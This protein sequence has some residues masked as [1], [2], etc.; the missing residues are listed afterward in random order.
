MYFE[1]FNTMCGAAFEPA[2]SGATWQ[3]VVDRH[4]ILRTAFLWEGLE[5][6]VQAVFRRV[7]VPFDAWTG[8]TWSRH[9]QPAKLAR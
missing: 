4:P 9:E 8:A 1:Q 2:P 3:E 7:K 5:E 6:P